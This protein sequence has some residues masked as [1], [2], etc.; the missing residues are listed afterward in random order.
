MM[1]TEGGPLEDGKTSIDM[2]MRMSCK[3][4]SLVLP[5]D[6]EAIRKSV[7]SCALVGVERFRSEEGEENLEMD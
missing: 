1:S 7:Q 6:R 4:L 2:S 3:F 5:A